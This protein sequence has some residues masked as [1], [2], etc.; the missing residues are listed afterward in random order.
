MP[1]MNIQT[2][3]SHLITDCCATA[4]FSILKK[5]FFLFFT[6]LDRTVKYNRGIQKSD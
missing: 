4:N 5:L 3:M 6:T 2:L 1:W